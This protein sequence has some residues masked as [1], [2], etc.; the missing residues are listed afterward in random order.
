MSPSRSQTLYTCCLIVLA[1]LCARAQALPED[2]NASIE[3]QSDQYVFD[4]KNGLIIYSGNAE[5][6]QGSLQ[7]NADKITV[8]YR[9]DNTVEIIEATGS[10]ARLQQQP[11]A[12]QDVVKASAEEIIYHRLDNTVEMR[13]SAQLEQNGAIMRGH[14]IHYDLTRELVQADS[15]EAGEERIFMTIPAGSLPE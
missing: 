6:K 8:H 13:A 15:D 7:I 11:S 14:K 4:Q 10:P 9:D 1:L 2:R 5:L 3:F 12:D